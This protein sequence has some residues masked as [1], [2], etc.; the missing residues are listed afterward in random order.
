MTAQDGLLSEKDIEKI[1][2]AMGAIRLIRDHYAS[3]TDGQKLMQE[4]LM[5][6]R[7]GD[8]LACKN[9]ADA[10]NAANHMKRVQ[11]APFETP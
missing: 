1:S 5:M 6:L 3:G 4:V 9:V 2:N 11:D 7:T 10:I 8:R